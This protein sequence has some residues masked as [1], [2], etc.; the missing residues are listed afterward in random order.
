MTGLASARRVIGAIRTG[1]LTLLQAELLLDLL[2]GPLRMGK[3]GALRGIGPS[4]ATAAVEWLEKRGLVERLRDEDDRRIIIARLSPDGVRL[5]T[6]ITQY[7][8]ET[9]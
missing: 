5:A 1:G 8:P 7:E 9:S 6:S 3:I 4:G 2:D